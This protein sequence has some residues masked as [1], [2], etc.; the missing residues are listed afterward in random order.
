MPVTR[1]ER[2][3]SRIHRLASSS[4]CCRQR[5]QARPGGR[6]HMGPNSRSYGVASTSITHCSRRR[7]LHPRSWWCCA[8]TSPPHSL[9]LT[10]SQATSW[11]CDSL[12]LASAV[13]APASK[14]SVASTAKL[15]LALKSLCPACTAEP[16]VSGK[17]CSVGMLA[18]AHVVARGDL[19]ARRSAAEAASP[20]RP[21][22]VPGASSP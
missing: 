5:S 3:A 11:P 16:S 14:P 6:T 9:P 22:P 21:W 1:A 8:S 4:S 7:S 10:R 13:S 19:A 17:A 20:A 2:L 12:S 15:R 18:A